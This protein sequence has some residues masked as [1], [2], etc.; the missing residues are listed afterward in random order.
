LLLS[1]TLVCLVKPASP[2]SGFSHSVLP[3][4][5]QM[6]VLMKGRTFTWNRQRRL[7]K[8]PISEP[9]RCCRAKAKAPRVALAWTFRETLPCLAL[10]THP[11][12][13]CIS[14]TCTRSLNW[15]NSC[16]GLMYVACP[17]FSSLWANT[18][19]DNR[20]QT[21]VYWDIQSGCV[22]C[23]IGIPDCTQNLCHN[24]WA[25]MAAHSIDGSAWAVQWAPHVVLCL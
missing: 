2:W 8:V 6:W 4:K 14:A 9:V 19:F 23:R 20:E 11:T 22:K 15:T 7:G 13:Y 16:Y 24:G 12:A 18:Q 10:S 3:R 21:V 25:R 17:A 1:G 5:T